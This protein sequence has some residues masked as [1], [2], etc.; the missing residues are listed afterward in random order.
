MRR[1]GSSCVQALESLLHVA[2]V[3]CQLSCAWAGLR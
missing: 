2:A 1:R 3:S